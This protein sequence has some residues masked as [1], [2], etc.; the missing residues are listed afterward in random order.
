MS[1]SGTLEAWE[2]AQLKTNYV[3]VRYLAYMP[4]LI[5]RVKQLENIEQVARRY[6]QNDATVEDLANAVNSF[7]TLC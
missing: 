4:R 1:I 2:R 5:E 7:D 3:V 6:V